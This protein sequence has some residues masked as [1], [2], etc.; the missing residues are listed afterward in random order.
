MRRAPDSGLDQAAADR[1]ARQ[2]DAVAHAELAEDVRPVALDGLR[3]DHE[4]LGDLLR[5]VRLGDQLH[6]LE[7]A[8][9]QRLEVAVLVLAREEVADQRRDGA[10]VEERLA[11][12]GGAARLDEVAVGRGLEHVTGRARLQRLEEVLLVVVHREDQR[13]QLGLASVELAGGLDARHPRHRH[14]EDGEVDRLL[15]RQL[16][17]LSAVARLRSW[18]WRGLA[19]RGAG[20]PAPRGIVTS[21]PGGSPGP[22]GASPP[23]SA[24]PP[25][26][27]TT[28]RSGSESR[29]SRRPRRTIA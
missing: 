21:R 29:T 8:G 14:V 28:S 22:P 12:D 11:A 16:D 1:V 26:S 19:A 15:E 13:P 6:H 5:R 23:P 27:A 2:L 9:C 17:G 4:D 10:G 7:L 20:T 18:G 25:A 3:A 24:P